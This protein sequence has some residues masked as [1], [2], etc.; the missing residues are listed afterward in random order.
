[1][2]SVLITTPVMTDAVPES[3][4][5]LANSAETQLRLRYVLRDRTNGGGARVVMSQIPRGLVA[6]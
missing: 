1:L 5:V 3:A 2:R 4:A 6:V